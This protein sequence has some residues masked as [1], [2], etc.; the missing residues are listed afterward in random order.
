M[1]FFTR[2]HICKKK[3]R[4][5]D[6]PNEKPVRDHCH[7]TGKYRGS[8]HLKCNL[9]L[10]ISA[11]KLKIPVIFH[12]LRG[13]DSHFIIQKLAELAK[14]EQISK[15]DVIPNN[16]EQYMAF[17]LGK[18][19]VFLDSFQFM[20]KSLDKLAEYLS[21]NE[22]IYTRQY[23][24]DERQFRLM[25]EKGVY[26]YDYMDSS[27]KFNDT[28]LP[29]KEDFCS[30]LKD[31][32]ISNDKYKHAKEVWN[33]LGIKNM[34]EYHDFYLKTDVLLLADVIEN[35]R[36]TC[37]EY[38]GLHPVHYVSSPGLSW[39]AMLKMT[40]ISLEIITD[41]DQQLFIEKGMRGGISYIAHRHAR[42]NNKYMKSY[43]PEKPTSYILDE[44]ANN[45]YGWAMI[46]PLPYASFRWVEPKYYGIGY[47]YE[48]D[49][50]YPEELHHLHNDYRLAP[51]KIMR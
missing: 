32:D 46:Q 49:L 22:F 40:G 31:E 26:P 18:H 35:F 33:T 7:V 27:E 50:E 42:A 8:A 9:K 23:F 48:V 25:T 14:E 36:E 1:R 43:N 24:T 28:Q 45:L 19:L 10:Q 12:N 37:L 3:Y 2:C 13:Y 29:K 5:N 39:D 15:I 44:D 41:I 20:N 38:Y 16:S 6:D 30:L 21:E 4:D 47:I 11:E 34:G 17:Y 51:E